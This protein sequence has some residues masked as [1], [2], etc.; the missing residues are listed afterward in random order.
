MKALTRY[1]DHGEFGGYHYIDMPAPECGP[2]DIIIRLKAAAIC[3]ADMKHWYAD[4]N[5]SNTSETL[6]NTVASVEDQRQQ[7]IGVSSDEELTKMIQYQNAYNAASRF[8]NVVSQ[9]I[10]TLITSL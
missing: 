5:G 10:E 9:M 8:I 3:G 7:A 2:D 4:L 1:C 6:S